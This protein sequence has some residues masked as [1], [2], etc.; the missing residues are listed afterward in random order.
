[1]DIYSQDGQIKMPEQAFVERAAQLQA[2]TLINIQDFLE[3]F[4]LQD[5]QRGRKALHALCWYPAR[6]F[7]RQMVNFDQQVGVEGLRPAARSTLRGYVRRLEV[8]GLEH[9]PADGPL[10]VLSNHP[11]MTDT[12]IL[13]TSLPR[14]DLKIVATE[15]PFL[16]A[17]PKISRHLIYVSEEPGQRMGVVRSTVQHLRNGGSALTFPAGQIE[18]DPACMPGAVQS[19]ETWSESITIF[20]RLAPEM[21]IVTAIV[22]GVVWS[23]ALRHPLTRLR[24]QLKDQERLGAAL[25]VLVQMLVPFYRPVTPRVAFSPPLAARHLSGGGSE[26]ILKAITDQARQLIES[27]PAPAPPQRV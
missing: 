25:Q 7:A 17:L 23:A 6:C 11:G 8:Q 21:Q 10:L 26:S 5:I 9:I 1:L 18:P 19:L 24:R 3:S 22:S 2:L 20:T 14:T 27:A 13:F 12:L 16:Q 4:G 15:R